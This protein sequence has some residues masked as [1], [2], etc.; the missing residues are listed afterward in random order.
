MKDCIT[1]ISIVGTDDCHNYG[2]SKISKHTLM[3]I[4]ILSK[5]FSMRKSFVRS[6]N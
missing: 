3:Q 2:I 4:N 5:E 1:Y 6:Y